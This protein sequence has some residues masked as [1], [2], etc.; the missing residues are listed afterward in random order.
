[1]PRSPCV[2]RSVYE[3]VIKY[4]A[5]DRREMDIVEG[6]IHTDRTNMS[7]RQVIKAV[8]STNPALS[9]VDF[10][11]VQVA[12]KYKMPLK[13]FLQSAEKIEQ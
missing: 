11:R 9:V 3:T 8:E 5:Y 12:V 2:I 10:T 4:K 6:T 13:T 7:T 1:M